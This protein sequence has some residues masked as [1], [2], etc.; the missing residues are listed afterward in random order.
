MSKDRCGRERKR[1]ARPYT[2]RDVGRVLLYAREDG[3][4]DEDI[5]GY[6]LDAYGQPSIA[7]AAFKVTNY[8]QDVA[9]L[10]A[11][12]SML[13]GI[14]TVAGGIKKLTTRAGWT[15][16]F[17]FTERFIPERYAP[18]Y[19]ALMV[20]VGGMEVLAA[21]AVEFSILVGNARSVNV[22]LG[23]ICAADRKALGVK[24]EMESVPVFELLW[25][26]LKLWDDTMERIIDGELRKGKDST[27]NN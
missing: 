9:Q 15:K 21:A 2:A 3:A 8:L 27:I 4:K 1:A 19:G 5:I 17:A 10:M 6:I 20:Y 7:C 24:Y 16:V 18:T 11:V 25:A 12:V 14:A 22:M 23:K 26:S 13:R